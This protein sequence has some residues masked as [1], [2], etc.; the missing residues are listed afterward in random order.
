ML[1]VFWHGPEGD[2]DVVPKVG[3]ISCPEFAVR[4]IFPVLGLVVCLV[5]RDDFTALLDIFYVEIVVF[6]VFDSKPD[7]FHSVFPVVD[8]TSSFFALPCNAVDDVK[9]LGEH[10]LQGRGASPITAKIE[11]TCWF[12]L[13]HDIGHPFSQVVSICLLCSG[14][15]GRAVKVFS[16]VVGRVNDN[17]VS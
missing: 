11:G 16:E 1:C 7:V 5:W 8:G 2:A 4:R 9:M 15:E 13:C 6:G 12:E 3:R 10:L 14:R 17:K